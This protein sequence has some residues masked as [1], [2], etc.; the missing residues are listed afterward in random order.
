MVQIYLSLDKLA[1]KLASVDLIDRPTDL[2]TFAQGFSLN[3]SLFTIVDVGHGKERADH[4]IKGTH[5]THPPRS[6]PAAHNA[7]KCSELSVITPRAATLYLAAAM[8][9]DIC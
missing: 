9:P 2:R 6:M 7:Q 1:Q 3:Q 4:K 5:S 8:M